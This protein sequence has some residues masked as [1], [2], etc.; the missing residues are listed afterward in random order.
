MVLMLLAPAVHSQEEKEL[1]T[2]RVPPQFFMGICP[3]KPFSGI[4]VYFQGVEDKRGDK[5]LGVVTKKKGK[6]PIRVYSD[7]PL[8]VLMQNYL[9]SLFDECGMQL[10]KNASQAPYRLSAGIEAFS[11]QEVKGILTGK[12]E[13][14]S[15]L[16]LSATGG[17]R[18]VRANVG[19]GVEFKKGKKHGIERLEETLNELLRE[20]LRQLVVSDQLQSLKQ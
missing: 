3:K 2:L 12:G 7:P 14:K 10:A 13:A 5:I 6:D 19:Y 15:R 4:K 11:A 17:G 8:E 18:T 1:L 16:S 20:T 9:N